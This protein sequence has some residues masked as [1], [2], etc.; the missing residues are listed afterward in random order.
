M[1]ARSW[2]PRPSWA[3]SAAMPAASLPTAS[4]PPLASSYTSRCA[5]LTPIPITRSILPPLCL[6]ACA[7]QPF[8]LRRKRG[9]ITLSGGLPSPS[10]ISASPGPALSYPRREHPRLPCDWPGQAARPRPRTGARARSRARRRER[11]RPA[12]SSRAR[13]TRRHPRPA[14]RRTLCPHAVLEGVQHRARLALR[15]LRPTR[16]RAAPATGLGTSIA[17]ATSHARRIW[18]ALSR[19]AIGRASRRARR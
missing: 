10:R 17:D 4:R 5:L 6:R 19:S 1:T 11:A 18:T 16:L 9:G 2:R 7:D 14:A 12:V 3:V 8:G 15:R 13:G